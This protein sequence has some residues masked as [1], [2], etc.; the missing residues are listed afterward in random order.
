M[1]SIPRFRGWLNEKAMEISDWKEQN[2]RIIHLHPNHKNI[3]SE[4]VTEIFDRMELEFG[5]Q[6]DNRSLHV[7]LAA[8]DAKIVGIA[9]VKESVVAKRDDQEKKVRLGIQRLY[10]R[11]EFRRK[12][13]AKAILKTIT[14]LHHKGDLLKLQEDVAFNSPTQLGKKLIENVLGSSDKVFTFSS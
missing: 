13:I 10:V 11:P 5:V 9:T 7:Y 14:I 2:G 1:T 4:F 6:D 3:R 8:Y 12:G